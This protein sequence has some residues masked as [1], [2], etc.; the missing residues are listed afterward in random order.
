MQLRLC[1]NPTQQLTAPYTLGMTAQTNKHDGYV[2]CEHKRRHELMCPHI[3]IYTGVDMICPLNQDQYR[4][5]LEGDLSKVRKLGSLSWEDSFPAGG[6]RPDD[7]MYRLVR[8][9]AIRDGNEPL[10]RQTL[11]S[12]ARPQT[13]LYY[14]VSREQIHANKQESG[15]ARARPTTSPT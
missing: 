5:G 15:C 9:G 11:M 4:I 12:R 10:H 7:F 3:G 13:V 1:M 8:L 14:K 6:P 2:M